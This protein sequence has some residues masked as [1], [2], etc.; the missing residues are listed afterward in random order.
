LLNLEHLLRIPNVDNGLRFGISDDEK[1][2]IYS[3]NKSGVWEIWK[4]DLEGLE[5]K[6]ITENT[7]GGK[8]SPRFSPNGKHIAYALDTNGSESFHITLHNSEDNSQIDLTPQVD[9]AQQPNF[10]FSPDGKSVAILSD[11]NGQFALYVLEIATKEKNLLLDIHRPIWDVVWSP[12]GK[13]IAVE[14]EWHKSDKTICVLHIESGTWIQLVFNDEVLNAQN[15]AWSPDSKSLAFSAENGEWHNIGI[16][17]IASNETTWLTDSTGDDTQPTWSRSGDVIGWVH[18]DGAKTSFQFKRG[19]GAVE[20]VKAGDGVH[21]FPQI[22]SDSV[23]ILYEDP[24]H[25]PD[26]WKINLDDGAAKQLT[27]SLDEELNIVQPKE[28][29]YAGKDGVRVPALLYQAENSTRAVINIHGGPNWLYQFLW[30]PFMIYMASRE[31]PGT[32]RWL[33]EWTANR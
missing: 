30:N 31:W 22:T 28:I 15:P 27:K 11:E 9:Y 16:F 14:A 26:I 17:D 10:D 6:C 13:Y 32:I 25:P 3:W 21:A 1:Q 7:K 33:N 2:I 12:D 18:A 20:Q 23:F 29:W 5:E 4:L 8:F 19:T 24:S